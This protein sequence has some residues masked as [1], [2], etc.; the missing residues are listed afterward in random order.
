MWY[1]LL[2]TIQYTA[3]QNFWLTGKQWWRRESVSNTKTAKQLWSAR[4]LISIPSI[5][6]L[7]MFC[8][9][10]NI[11]IPLS[12]DYTSH[13]SQSG[14]LH[15][16]ILID[17]SI[18]LSSIY[19]ISLS[20]YLSFKISKLI[21]SNPDPSKVKHF[22]SSVKCTAFPTQTLTTKLQLVACKDYY[23]PASSQMYWAP[24]PISLQPSLMNTSSTCSVMAHIK[25]IISG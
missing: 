18:Y 4:A 20:I 7:C 12:A 19:L 14:V 24:M 15:T 2:Y 9:H 13:Y 22:S 8:K 10:A 3:P 5:F 25:M 21:L 11:N 23:H 1:W 16:F 17:W 6:L